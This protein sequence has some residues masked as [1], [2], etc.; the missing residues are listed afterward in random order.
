MSAIAILQQSSPPN[1]NKSKA[2]IDLLCFAD[3][4]FARS[5]LEDFDKRLAMSK[6]IFLVLLCCVPSAFVSAQDSGTDEY[7]TGMTVVGTPGAGPSCPL[8]VWFVEPDTPAA[9][10]L[11]S[12]PVTGCLPLTAIAESMLLKPTHY[13]TPKIRIQSNSNLR[14]NTALIP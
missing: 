11:Q 6:L 13:F 14:V 12:N 3:V 7:V 4:T 9:K 10:R 2:L 8:I 1:I 5:E